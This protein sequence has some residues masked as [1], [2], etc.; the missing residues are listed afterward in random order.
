MGTQSIVIPQKDAG[1]DQPS[2]H[3]HMNTVHCAKPEASLDTVV[4]AQRHPQ[5]SVGQ[6]RLCRPWTTQEVLAGGS[7]RGHNA[8]LL[9]TG[10]CP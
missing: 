9:D 1:L 5:H 10:L 3:G 6:Q 2:T 7:G 8:E 4:M